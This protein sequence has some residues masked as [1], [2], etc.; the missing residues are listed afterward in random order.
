MN[1]IVFPRHFQYPDL[2]QNNK[3]NDTNTGFGNR[4]GLGLASLRDRAS[5]IGNNVAS[6]VNDLNNKT[7][8]TR[9]TNPSSAPTKKAL[10]NPTSNGGNSSNSIAT[11]S[12]QEL[13]EVLTKMNKKVKALSALRTQLQDKLQ[14]TENERDK[15]KSLVINSSVMTKRPTPL[16]NNDENGDGNTNLVEL[17]VENLSKMW[18]EMEMQEEQEL[19]HLKAV[20]SEQSQQR[21]V[22]NENIKGDGSGGEYDN[23]N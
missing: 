20:L 10:D 22:S 2:I 11:A 19:L 7:T 9:A 6:S 18:K 4:F 5:E 13:V 12:K 16:V 8:E 15:L 14:T 23:N 21:K 3:S 17:S 1:S